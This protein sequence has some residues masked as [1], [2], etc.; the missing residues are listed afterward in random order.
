LKKAGENFS[1]QT[2][3]YLGLLHP[4]APASTHEE[5]KNFSTPPPR[6]MGLI[7]L[8][9]CGFWGKIGKVPLNC[10]LL[11]Q[12]TPIRLGP[13]TEKKVFPVAKQNGYQ[14][15]RGRSGRSGPLKV[16][17]ILL[18][19]ILLALAAVFFWLQDYVVYTPDGIRL[20]LPFGQSSPTPVPTPEPTPLPPVEPVV[21]TPTPAVVTPEDGVLRAVEVSLDSLLAGNAKAEM[22][23][24]G[25]NAVLL[26]MKNEEGQLAYVSNLELAKN[27]GVSG[28]DLAVNQ[29]IAALKEDGVY[30]VAR[31]DCFRD[32]QLPRYQSD[33]AILTNSGYRWT[34][35]DKLRWSSPTSSQVRDYLTGVAA[36]L[37]GLGFDEI[38]LN[39]AGYPT[40]GNLHY[41]KKGEAYDSA[42]F[43]TVVTGFYRQ[44]AAAVE[45]QGGRLSVITTPDVLTSGQNASSGQTIYSLAETAWRV[46][47]VSGAED[48]P[49][50]VSA[51]ESAGMTRPE[52][53]LVLMG[54]AGD[55]DSTGSWAALS[56]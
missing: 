22:E 46:W 45:E 14:S 49:A 44:A 13:C 25:G 30:L 27:A 34:D 53:Q 50:L 12:T 29:A 21:V 8:T 7:P 6:D 4:I 54:G 17:V 3:L 42:A 18:A 9:L 52:E 1:F 11:L 5:N 23:E 56:E 16:L 39:T 41:I 26:N 2:F 15:Y 51:L 48:V 40:A 47:L 55:A 24:A 35:P 33:L 28:A 31:M 20:D 10:I 38:V 43:A 19:I 32:N 37:A 36:E